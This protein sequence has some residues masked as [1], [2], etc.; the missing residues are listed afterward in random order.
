MT[1][2]DVDGTRFHNLGVTFD[3]NT[4]KDTQ[5]LMQRRSVT[6]RITHVSNQSE[7]VRTR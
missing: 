1:T 4:P 5:L 6:D 2:F 3:R 7:L